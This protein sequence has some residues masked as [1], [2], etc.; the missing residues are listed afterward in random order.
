MLHIATDGSKKWMNRNYLWY[1]F[2]Y[3]FKQ[4]GV[5][6]IICPIE[7]SNKVCISFV[8]HIGFVHEATL[9]DAAPKGDLLIYSMAKDQCKWLK[10]REQYRGEAQSTKAA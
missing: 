9:K 3:P 7:S 4:L 1:V 5:N 8:E 10:L 6:K 2:Y